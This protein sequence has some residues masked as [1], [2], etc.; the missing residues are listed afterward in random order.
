ML[1][2][3][4][5][6]AKVIHKLSVVCGTISKNNPYNII[7]KLLVCVSLFLVETKFTINIEK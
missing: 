3:K 6:L 5:T 1:K 2:S 7:S 4:K